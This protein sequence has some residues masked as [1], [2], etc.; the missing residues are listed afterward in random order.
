MTRCSL[1]AVLQC[2]ESIAAASLMIA[3]APAGAAGRSLAGHRTIL[4]V[5]GSGGAAV[6]SKQRL[7]GRMR[8]G[9]E[10]RGSHLVSSNLTVKTC[11]LS[12]PTRSDA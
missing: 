6:D 11:M 8:L 12:H 1:L 3:V 7:S 4:E 2:S 9:I 5:G 10:G